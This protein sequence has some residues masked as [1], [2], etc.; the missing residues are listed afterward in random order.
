MEEIRVNEGFEKLV[1]RAREIQ[2]KCNDYVVD[3]KTMRMDDELNIHFGTEQMP[4]SEF[5][6]SGLCGKLKVP[7]VY[8]NRC[9]QSNKQLAADNINN[10]LHDDPRQFMVRAYDG[11]VRGLLSGSYSK[12]DA[13]EILDAVSNVFDMGKYKLKGSFVSEERLHI[14]LVENEMLPIENEDLFCRNHSR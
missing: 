11:R 13:P 6:S 14:R 12:F 1:E 9:A 3:A 8:F 7:T 2:A 10:W 4:M 5:A